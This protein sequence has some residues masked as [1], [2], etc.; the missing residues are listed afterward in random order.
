MENYVTAQLTTLGW[1]MLLGLLCAL[2]YDLLRLVR[3]R[4]G[5]AWLMHVLD[6][7]YTPAALLAVVLLALGRGEGEL[8]LYMLLG[9]ALGAA[10]YTLLLRRALQPVW[11]F[12]IDVLS[13]FIRLV[14]LPAVFLCHV[15]K[16]ICTAAKKLFHFWRK[17]AT[18][19]LY[20]WKYFLF[21]E[22][23]QKEGGGADREKKNAK[24]KPWRHRAVGGGAADRRDR[25]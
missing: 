16:K 11:Q 18:I 4:R 19:I 10:M 12:W 15:V 7:V 5:S 8:R 13:A 22:T 6:G 3:L 24:E 14:C 2:V 20:K 1:S 23:R 21:S 25:R 17:Y 9:M